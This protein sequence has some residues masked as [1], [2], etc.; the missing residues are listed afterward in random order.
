MEEGWD[1]KQGGGACRG[2]HRHRRRCRLL[3]CRLHRAVGGGRGCAQ[4]LQ[5]GIGAHAGGT[6]HRRRLDLTRGTPEARHG[7][8]WQVLGAAGRVCALVECALVGVVECAGGARGDLGRSCCQGSRTRPLASSTSSSSSSTCKRSRAA[9]SSAA[10]RIAACD[11]SAAP[12]RLRRAPAH[13]PTGSVQEDGMG[14]HSAAGRWSE[15]ISVRGA[16]ARAVLC[17]AVRWGVWSSLRMSA[18]R[19]AA[20]NR[21]LAAAGGLIGLSAHPRAAHPS[22]QRRGRLRRRCRVARGAYTQR[23][24]ST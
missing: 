3:A 11:A 1:R 10:A 16:Q 8:G 5:L 2:Q 7:G 12:G 24:G 19:A 4:L 21:T 20:S 9:S 18:C 17:R 15:V 6:L 22:S 14:R 23:E 13:A